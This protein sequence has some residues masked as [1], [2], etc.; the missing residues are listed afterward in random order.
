MNLESFISMYPFSFPSQWSCFSFLMFDFLSLSWDSVLLY[1]LT[2]N[3]LHRPVW[4]WT[5]RAL[6]ASAK[7]SGCTTMPNLS[8]FIVLSSTSEIAFVS[9]VVWQQWCNVMLL[10]GWLSCLSYLTGCEQRE[11]PPQSL[12]VRHH[13]CL[14]CCAVFFRQGFTVAR[15]ELRDLPV[16]ISRVLRLKAC[17]IIA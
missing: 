2:W 4:P 9:S 17:T 10:R 8:F 1:I 13:I 12:R 6:P 16:S 15:L 14:T 7:Y 5:H 3:L 11:A